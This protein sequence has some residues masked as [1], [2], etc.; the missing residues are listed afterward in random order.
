LEIVE[1]ADKPT[2]QHKVSHQPPYSLAMVICDAIAIDPASGKRTIVGCFSA[3]LAK[4]FPAV[5]GPMA[6]YIAL[7]D[8]HGK[9]PFTLRLMDADEQNDPLFKADGDLEFADARA[10]LEM[11]LRL[12]GISFPAP[13]EY[14]FQLF[15]GGEPVIERRIVVRKVEE[16]TDDSAKS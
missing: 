10:V 3:V 15:A 9:I 2:G 7:T 8:G 6:L 13:G 1:M 14:R 12:S 4:E 11:D 5:H 16:I